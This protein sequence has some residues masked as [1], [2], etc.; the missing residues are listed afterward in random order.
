MKSG[1]RVEPLHTRRLSQ[2]YTRFDS[3]LRVLEG[4]VPSS[5]CLT[6]SIIV[7][8]VAIRPVAGVK[9]GKPQSEIDAKGGL[10][11]QVI[12]YDVARGVDINIVLQISMQVITQYL[13]TGVYIYPALATIASQIIFINLVVFDCGTTPPFDAVILV[14]V[15][16]IIA[17][18]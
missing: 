7:G 2:C 10:F 11:Y 3:Y 5:I 8:S 6:R 13:T 1:V 14:I 12:F 15:N 16:G 17:N 9:V 18:D 4:K